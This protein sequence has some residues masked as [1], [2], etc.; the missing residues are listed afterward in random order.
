MVVAGREV[1]GKNSQKMG[2]FPFLSWGVFEKSFDKLNQK[3]E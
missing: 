3:G 2:I 1:V